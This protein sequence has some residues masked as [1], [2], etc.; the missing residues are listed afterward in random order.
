ILLHDGRSMLTP[1]L[2]AQVELA[3]AGRVEPR[4]VEA[5]ALEE[6]RE[7]RLA[8]PG[9]HVALGEVGQ[10]QAR[11]RA[12]RQR[13]GGEE[14]LELAREVEPELARP[15]R[16][17]DHVQRLVAAPLREERVDNETIAPRHERAD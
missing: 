8:Q 2:W 7:R 9:G 13:L 14:L 16:E 1:K 17:L 3:V 4:H 5:P 10:D 6:R 15:G 11:R 12:P